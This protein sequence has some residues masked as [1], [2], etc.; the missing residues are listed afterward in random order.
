MKTVL[1]ISA[2]EFIE[3]IKQRS[4]IIGTALGVLLI[5]GLSFMSI[6]F[7]LLS[8][9]FST[10]LAIVA[11]DARIA[12]TVADSLSLKG[13]SDR[14]HLTV[15]P[16]RSHGSHLPPGVESALRARKYDAALV[17]YLNPQR[18]LA[19]TYYPRQSSALDEGDN[20]KQ[21]LLRAV[22]VTDAAHSQ[23]MHPQSEIDFPFS[24]VNLNDRYRS[25]A[26]QSKS[27]V[28]VYFL[29]L[30]MYISVILYGI[31]VAQG[32]IEEKSNRVMELMIGAVRPSQLLAGK[33]FG[34]GTLAIVQLLIIG[35]AAALVHVAAAAQWGDRLLNSV[36]TTA[37]ASQ[38]S[39]SILTVPFLTWLYLLVFFLLGFFTYATMFAGVGALASKAEDLQQSSGAFTLPIVAAYL[40][41]MLV[42]M[43]PDKPIVVGASLIPML[44]PMVMFARV[45]TSNVPLWQVAV[46]IGA[47]LVAIWLFTLLA[48][49]LYRV[50]VLMYGKQLAPKEILRALRAHM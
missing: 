28:L 49:K 9:T 20:L 21:R 46:S 10:R 42:L 2:R 26:E 17:A 18:D 3:R 38:Q 37:A 48:A 33:I 4:F 40:L 7:G 16:Q 24:T 36:H 25:E 23:G 6:V 31:Y 14:Y 41:S 1:I 30:L 32:V 45:A 12:K 34:I 13:Q 27:Q 50:G 8:S 44:S 15:L 47:S 5:V 39:L 35:L 43:D 29:L 22:I 19:F 11:P